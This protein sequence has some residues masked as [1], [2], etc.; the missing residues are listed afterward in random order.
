ML[1]FTFGFKWYLQLIRYSNDYS[2]TVWVHLESIPY[3]LGPLVCAVVNV[4][5]IYLSSSSSPGTVVKGLSSTIRAWRMPRPG[6]TVTAVSPAQ[7]SV[8][9]A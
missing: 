8:F 5:L 3:L 1:G 6:V 9:A 7:T 4:K 2:R